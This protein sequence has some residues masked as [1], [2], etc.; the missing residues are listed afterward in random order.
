MK[1]FFERV[2]SATAIYFAVVGSVNAQ[3]NDKVIAA[4]TTKD[5]TAMNAFLSK[6]SLMEKGALL[7]DA[8]SALLPEKSVKVSKADLRAVKADFR[9]TTYFKKVFKDVPDPTWAVG[10]FGIFAYYTKDDAKTIAVFDKKGFLVQT[11]AYYIPE[12]TPANIRSIVQDSYPYDNI[13]QAIK[14]TE[15]DAEFFIVQLEDQRTFKQLSV[16]NGMIELMAEYRKKN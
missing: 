14:V 3:S 1:K 6:T 5:N 2:L 7:E 12:K 15:K 9:A 16:C 13:A 11:L 4:T 10:K 8:K